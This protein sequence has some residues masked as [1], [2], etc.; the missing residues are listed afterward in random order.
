MPG[1]RFASFRNLDGEQPFVDDVA[2]A[3]DNAGTV[4]VDADRGVVGQ[5]V[6]AHAFLEV[7]LGDKVRMPANLLEQRMPRCDP[8]KIVMIGRLPVR[9][10]SRV[11]RGQRGQPPV[12][13]TFVVLHPRR[14]LAG[15]ESV[16]E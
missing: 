15:V 6:E 16:G 1:D 11:L 3:I 2:Q 4:N 12:G 14:C 5:R 7:F 10:E 8:F 13:M 9:R